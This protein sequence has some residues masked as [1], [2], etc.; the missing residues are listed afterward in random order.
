[1]TSRTDV[2]RGQVARAVHRAIASILPGL[3]A[4]AISGRDHLRDL[5]ADS[6]DRVEIILMVTRELG[7][8]EPLARFAPLRNIDELVD[9]LSVVVR[10]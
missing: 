2:T 9:F 4:E 3:P 6:V 1:M 5:G 10:R 7:V 8:D